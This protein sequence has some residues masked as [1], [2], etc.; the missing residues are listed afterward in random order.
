M[1]KEGLFERFPA[2][3]VYGM[4]NWP[5][6]P[7]GEIAVRT[8]PMMAAC[9]E[10]EITVEGT[11]AHGAMPH[12]GLD[13][14]VASRRSSPAY[15]RSWRAT[16]T[17]WSPGV[18]SVTMIHGGDA[19]NVIPQSVELS[20]TVRTFKPEV[21]ETIA[22]G[23]ERIAE[24]TAAAFGAKATVKVEAR[25]PRDGQHRRRDR[26][27]RGRRPGRGGRGARAPRR[28]ALHGLRGL[29]LH[30]PGPARQLYLDR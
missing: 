7:P 16:S 19:F 10:F 2:E 9:D 18:V 24:S 29:R 4:H 20:G 3:A 25:F 27:C 5:G 26:P 11:G 6:M 13:P 14:V 15:S 23:I 1:V 28:R 22:A 30:A 12:L 8:G 21:R 17:R